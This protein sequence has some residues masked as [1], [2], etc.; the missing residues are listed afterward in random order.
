MLVPPLLSQATISRVSTWMGDCQG[1]QQLLLQ[2]IDITQA[3][4]GAILKLWI[5][6]DK[7]HF[8]GLGPN[9]EEC[10]FL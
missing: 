2:Y 10:H 7:G 9:S 6:L 3:Q 4:A 1:K 8:T 5:S